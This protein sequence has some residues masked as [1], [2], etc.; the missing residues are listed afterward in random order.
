MGW[1]S[2]LPLGIALALAVW[3]CHGLFR[4]VCGYRCLACRG[5][6]RFSGC[7]SGCMDPGFNSYTC[8]QCGKT[9]WEQLGR[10]RVDYPGL[11]GLDD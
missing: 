7:D 2:W 5:R 11:R 10:L 1:E 9:F 4:R 8:R 3:L 6:A